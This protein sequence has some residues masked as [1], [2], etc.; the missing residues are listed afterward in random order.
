MKLSRERKVYL[1][2]LTVGAGVLGADHFL[3][4]PSSASASITAATAGAPE[5]GSTPTTNGL[6]ESR[7]VERVALHEQLERMSIT[8]DDQGAGLAFAIDPAWRAELTPI[9]P[10]KAAIGAAETPQSG[11][12]HMPK[13]TM[14][15]EDA[16]GGVAVMDGEAIRVGERTKDGTLLVSLVKGVAVVEVG[17]VE[18]TIKVSAEPELKSR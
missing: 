13:I 9:Q 4:G 12:I 1:A 10:E 16:T 17:G 3:G 5:N 2:V 11:P 7:R 6:V 8:L 14:V 15:F 18:H